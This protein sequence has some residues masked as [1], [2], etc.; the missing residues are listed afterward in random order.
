[1]P[2]RKTNQHR[3]IRIGNINSRPS[4]K[5]SGYL[6]VAD[7]AA[8]SIALPVTIVQG[9]SSGPTLVV[10]AGEHGCEY[11]GIMAAVRLIASITPEKIK[12][13][14]IVV[15][16]ANPPAFEERTLFVN[17]IDAV[18]LYASYPG[19]LAGTVSHMMAH[20]IFSQIAKKADFLVHLHGGDYNEALVPF[21][22]YAHT[23]NRS[24]D[25]MSRKL[26]S[27]FPVDY[28]LEA[29]MAREASSGS[30]KGTS[31]AATG[32]GTLYGEA[33][34]EQIPSTMCESGGEGKVEEKFV[35]IHYDGIMNVMRLIG[36]LTGVP[37]LREKQTKLSSPVLVSNRKAGLFNPF[38]K[39]GEKVK[40]GQ[41]IG[42]I[43]NFQGQVLETLR[44]PISGMVVDRIN[45]AAADSYPTQKQPYLFYIAKTE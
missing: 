7:K 29:V 12:G 14:L 26:A 42:E 43:L 18:N 4:T 31:Y 1:M 6:N 5:T 16:L 37:G 17:P 38:V 39:I 23:G 44:T 32:A 25:S 36:M 13:T 10:I 8:S 24:V 41:P 9:Q 40:K 45:F 30:P 22:Y 34:L 35:Q 27:C 3:A 2:S 20:E 19:S 11:C 15:P 33:S 28:V 21:N